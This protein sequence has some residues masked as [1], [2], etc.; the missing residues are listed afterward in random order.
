LREILNVST[1][2]TLA[3][4][5]QTAFEGAT[6]RNVYAGFGAAMGVLSTDLVSDGFTGE[7][8]GI[9]TVFGSIAGLEFDEQRARN[10][11]G[12]DWNILRGYQKLHACCRYVQPA[13]DALIGLDAEERVN[14]EEV[15]VID[16]WTSAL[17]ASMTNAEPHNGLAAKFSM[18]HTL[19]AYLVLRQTGVDA[20]GD[21]AALDPRIRALGARVS[22]HADAEMEARIPQDRPARVRV[23]LTGGRVRERTERQPRGEFDTDPTSDEQINEKFRTLARR[24]LI[25]DNVEQ[26][27]ERLWNVEQLDDVHEITSLAAGG[28]AEQRV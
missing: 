15:E 12:S 13:L 14:P 18:P 1:S 7:Q 16:V 5:F 27:R 26:L 23:R 28:R 21:A 6:V 22:V 19:A 2:L 20:F 3:T 10:G 4:S 11:M 25:E 9:A 24:V 8:N 17:A